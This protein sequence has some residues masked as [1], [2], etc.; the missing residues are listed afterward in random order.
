MHSVP[1]GTNWGVAIGFGADPADILP[2]QRE[3]YNDMAQLKISPTTGSVISPVHWPCYENADNASIAGNVKLPLYARLDFDA[4]PISLHPDWV[5]VS[6]LAA[7]GVRVSSNEDR[8]CY[9]CI[10]WCFLRKPK[11]PAGSTLGS[12]S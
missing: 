3:E 7:R 10:E 6:W 9:I 4:V 11:S 1:E 5:L 8:D 2:C 12:K